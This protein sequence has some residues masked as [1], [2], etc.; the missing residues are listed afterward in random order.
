MKI[1]PRN[2][3]LIAKNI[4]PPTAVIRRDSAAWAGRSEQFV[5]S[6]DAAAQSA[7]GDASSDRMNGVTVPAED[8]ARMSGSW[9]GVWM[10]LVTWWP[11]AARRRA[12]RRETRGAGESQC[13]VDNQD[14]AAVPAFAEQCRLGGIVWLTYGPICAVTNCN[15]ALLRNLYVLA[16][17]TTSP[18]DRRPEMALANSLASELFQPPRRV[19]RRVDVTTRALRLALRHTGS[20]CNRQR[21]VWSGVEARPDRTAPSTAPENTKTYCYGRLEIGI[22]SVPHTGTVVH[23]RRHRRGACGKVLMG[24]AVDN[25]IRCVFGRIHH[26]HPNLDARRCPRHL[27]G[28]AGLGRDS[29]GGGKGHVSSRASAITDPSTASGMHGDVR[30]ISGLGGTAAGSA[31]HDSGHVVAKR[32]NGLAK[33]SN[34]LASQSAGLALVLTPKSR[35][36]R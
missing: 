28:A 27:R 16:I 23:L 19:S 30:D 36:Q 31:G 17:L 6:A 10:M 12:R 32:A 25:P 24:R 35:Y 20:Y 14:A 34:R 11:A 8:A 2:T 7:G 13:E 5:K 3:C 1:D 15:T 33:P 29:A 22:D 4:L 26:G 21:D 18:Y 9:A